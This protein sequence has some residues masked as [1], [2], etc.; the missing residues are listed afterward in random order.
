MSDAA[1]EPAIWNPQQGYFRARTPM[2]A[3]TL[4]GVLIRNS[5]WF[6]CTPE[7]DDVWLFATKGEADR[8]VW[9]EAQAML[10][11]MKGMPT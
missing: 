6:E 5:M 1:R 8:T 3:A 7:P 11:D 10:D 2:A 4:T 9:R